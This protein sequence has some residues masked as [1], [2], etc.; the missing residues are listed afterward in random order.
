VHYALLCT[1]PLLNCPRMPA[2]R[3]QCPRGRPAC[4][5]DRNAPFLTFPITYLR[6]GLT[7]SLWKALRYLFPVGRELTGCTFSAGKYAALW[8]AVVPNANVFP[9]FIHVVVE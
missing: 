4:H 6:E 2:W 3:L 1:L 8:L 5:L 7:A 9:L